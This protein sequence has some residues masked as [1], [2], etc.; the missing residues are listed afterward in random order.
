MAVNSGLWDT[1]KGQ[2]AN[3]LNMALN[4]KGQ[5]G[6]PAK[7]TR[8][9]NAS[10]LLYTYVSINL[11]IVCLLVGTPGTINRVQLFTLP[12]VPVSTTWDLLRSV[13]CFSI[14]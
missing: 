10:I 9:W 7:Q 12:S 8:K 3:F 5:A 14:K 4:S 2:I 1:L 11:Q 6:H 13:F